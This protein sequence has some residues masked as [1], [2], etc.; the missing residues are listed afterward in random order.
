MMEEGGWTLEREEDMTAPYAYKGTD[1]M[2]FDDTTSTSI[3]AK[4]ILLRELAGLS[5][6]SSEHDDWTH[7]CSARPLLDTIHYTFTN[8]ARKS[9][10]AQL[11][12]LQ[13]LLL[14]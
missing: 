11:L 4:Y 12:S 13:V 5:V 8:L 14:S 6:V 3:K 10:A 7:S 2:A 1:W 9:R